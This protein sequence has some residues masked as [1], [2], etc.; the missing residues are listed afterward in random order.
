[1]SSATELALE[2]RQLR[3]DEG[4]VE[5][6]AA[7]SKNKKPRRVDFSG[8]GELRDALKAQVQSAERFAREHNRIVT[9]VFHDVDGSPLIVRGKKSGKWNPSSPFRK[10]WE[11]AREA[12]GYTKNLIHGF[13]RTAVRNFT[14]AG[15]AD[16]VAMQ[17]T[18]HKT[19]SVFQRYDITSND[20]VRTAGEMVAGHVIGVAE[21]SE[22]QKGRVRQFNR[23]GVRARR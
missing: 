21:P 22:R 1:M 14:R 18:G 20:D 17:I 4:I 8:I 16:T 13:R 19:R 6:D 3:F 7:Q 5:L 10:A 23:A 2:L 15:I 9:H 12:A 11:R